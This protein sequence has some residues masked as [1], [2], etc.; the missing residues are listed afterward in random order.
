MTMQWLA[1]FLSQVV[2]LPVIDQT[3]ISGFYKVSI[4]MSMGDMMAANRGV[5]MAP[6]DPSQP[7]IVDADLTDTLLGASLKKLGLKLTKEKGSLKMLVVDH[8]DR[9]SPN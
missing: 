9:P 6:L 8:I 5:P 2:D 7:E 3:H 1:D 4:D